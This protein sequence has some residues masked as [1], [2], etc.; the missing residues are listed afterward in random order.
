MYKAIDTASQFRDEFRAA[1]RGDQ[2]SYEA[3]GLLF[4]YLEEADSN[5]Q[6]D[7]VAICCEYIEDS[8]K[9]IVEIYNI[10]T[11]NADSQ[12]SDYEEQRRQIVYDYLSDRTSVVGDTANGFVYAQF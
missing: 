8:V 5:Y 11:S 3:L 10:D 4:D 7:V 2:F 12:A 1:G 6:L 9:D